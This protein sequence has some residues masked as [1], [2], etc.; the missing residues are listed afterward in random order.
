MGCLK[1]RKSDE[2]RGT[3]FVLIANASDPLFGSE[4]Q[5]DPKYFVARFERN[6]L[7]CSAVPY[8]RMA[9]LMSVFLSVKHSQV[10]RVT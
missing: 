3:A 9:V 4:R 10:E 8:F 2:G 7:C 5:K 1:K 6:M